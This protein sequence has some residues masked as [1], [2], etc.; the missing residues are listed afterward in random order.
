MKDIPVNVPRM[1]RESPRLAV[2]IESSWR[3]RTTAVDP[4]SSWSVSSE[5]R[6]LS[7]SSNIEIRVSLGEVKKDD[8]WDRK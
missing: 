3:R 7:H 6:L 8:V 2:W 5:N 1:A 4:D